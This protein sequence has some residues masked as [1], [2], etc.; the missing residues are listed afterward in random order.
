MK[1]IILLF[2][3]FALISCKKNDEKIPEMAFIKGGHFLMGSNAIKKSDEYPAKH[4][5]VND[6]YIGKYEIT[7]KQFKY[8]LDENPN[9]KPSNREKLLEKKLVDVDYL[10]NWKND[11]YPK[12]LENH[13]VGF[14]SWFAAVAYCNWLS[15]VTGKEVRLPDEAE[16]EYAAGNG[17]KHDIYAIMPMEKT[18]LTCGHNPGPYKTTR[19]VGSHKSN[20]FGLYDMNGNVWELTM[21]TYDRYPF[22]PAK[23]NSMK[24]LKPNR[25]IIMR[26]GSFDTMFVYSTNIFRNFIHAF[27]TSEEVG[28]RIVIA[29]KKKHQ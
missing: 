18:D 26:G 1:K 11:M 6:F 15:K 20:D 13:P 19:P 21:S 16:W 5:Y 7:Y 24:T 14:V 17:E 4:V 2:L 9:W 28:F 22:I 3:I 8:F 10:D 27:R 23:V 29:S 12:K 25:R